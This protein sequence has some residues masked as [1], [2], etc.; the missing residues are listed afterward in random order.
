MAADLLAKVCANQGEE[1]H[2]VLDKYQSPSIKDPE[3]SHGRSPTHQ[4]FVIT[5]PDQAQRSSGTELLKNGTFKEEFARFVL[6][7]WKKPQY[8]PIIG[9]KKLYVSHGGVCMHEDD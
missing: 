7:E 9:A 5:G 4:S 3:R 1:I 6:E 2:L 8:G